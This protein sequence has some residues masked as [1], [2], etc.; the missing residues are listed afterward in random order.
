MLRPQGFKANSLLKRTLLKE[1]AY[2]EGK[3]KQLKTVENIVVLFVLDL[4]DNLLQHDLLAIFQQY[5]LKTSLSR[6]YYK[7]DS[8]PYQCPA[9]RDLFERTQCV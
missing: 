2:E 1:I 9:R 4:H 3:T 8:A 7:L 5:I 6:M